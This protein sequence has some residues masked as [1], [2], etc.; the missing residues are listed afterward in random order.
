[1]KFYR[2]VEY[3]IWSHFYVDHFD[4]VTTEFELKFEYHL[5]LNLT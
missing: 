4:L 1:M 5:C 2:E 3:D